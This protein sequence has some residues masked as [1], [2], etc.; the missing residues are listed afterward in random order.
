[1]AVE[2]R[3]VEWLNQETLSLLQYLGASICNVDSPQQR[4]AGSLTSSRAYL[5][6]HG[7]KDWYAYNYSD[8]E[9]GEIAELAR[10]LVRIGASRVYIFFNNDYEGYAPANALTL[11]GM[12]G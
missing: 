6:L 4:L 9:L 2:F 10:S 7:R 1:V 3:R 12:L 5:R 11:Q 8:D